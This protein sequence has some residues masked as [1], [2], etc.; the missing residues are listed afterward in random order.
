METDKNYLL[1]ATYKLGKMS[2]VRLTRLFRYLVSKKK[3]ISQVFLKVVSCVSHMCFKA[4]SRV[5]LSMLYGYFKVHSKLSFVVAGFKDFSWV[6][7]ESLKCV[8]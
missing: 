5:H 1:I 2:F 7:Q 3:I 4:V 6:F 8:S